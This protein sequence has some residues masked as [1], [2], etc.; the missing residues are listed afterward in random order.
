MQCKRWPSLGG[1]FDQSCTHADASQ[2]SNEKERKCLFHLSLAWLRIPR[3]QTAM[4]VWM[5]TLSKRNFTHIWFEFILAVLLFSVLVSKVAGRS[6]VSLVQC[7][8]AFLPLHCSSLIKEMFLIYFSDC[9]AHQAKQNSQTL[10]NSQTLEAQCVPLHH[11]ADYSTHNPPAI[12]QA[13]QL[14]S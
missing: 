5:H 12:H 7:S 4:L 11:V 8:V 1:E 3:H 10:F 6:E 13:E 14:H 9:T 2:K